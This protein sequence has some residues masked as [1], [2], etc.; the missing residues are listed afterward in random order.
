MRDNGY[1]HRQMRKRAA[2][3]TVTLRKGSERQVPLLKTA[4]E[5]ERG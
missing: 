1:R 4:E 2:K 5:K 3:S